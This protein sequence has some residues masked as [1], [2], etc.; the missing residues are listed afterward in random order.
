MNKLNVLSAMRLAPSGGSGNLKEKKI[1]TVN[2]LPKVLSLDSRM[3]NDILPPKKKKSKASNSGISDNQSAN[4]KQFV[5]PTKGLD[6][7]AEGKAGEED[8]EEDSASDD[9]FNN[10]NENSDS[11]SGESSI[12]MDG[13]EDEEK[14]YA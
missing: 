13:E 4:T 8:L 3:M 9:A 5:P 12:D 10:E 6:G 7:I 14:L 1:R 2:N 11:D